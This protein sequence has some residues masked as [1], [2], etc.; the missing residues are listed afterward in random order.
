MPNWV[1]LFSS[2]HHLSPCIKY[3]CMR[4][5]ASFWCWSTPLWVYKIRIN[6]GLKFNSNLIWIGDKD[7]PIFEF[8]PKLPLSYPYLHWDTNLKR[9]SVLYEIRS[10]F[11]HEKFES[12]DVKSWELV[13]LPCVRNKGSVLPLRR[14]L[15]VLGFQL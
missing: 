5:F 2:C 9:G 14:E 13:G 12:G 1:G 10:D 7:Q 4:F 6:F 8:K 15:W 3:F 11:W